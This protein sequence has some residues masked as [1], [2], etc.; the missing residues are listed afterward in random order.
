MILFAF[1]ALICKAQLNYAPCGRDSVRMN[2]SASE[3]I[4]ITI[5]KKTPGPNKALYD[6]L[7]FYY[8]NYNVKATFLPDNLRDI[9]R[10]IMSHRTRNQNAFCL[11]LYI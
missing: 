6:N 5:F 3:S 10:L 11:H 8:N 9:I 7:T 2:R 4:A 1:C